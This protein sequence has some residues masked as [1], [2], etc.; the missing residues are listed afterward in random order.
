MAMVMNKMD[1]HLRSYSFLPTGGESVE[2]E[3][4]DQLAG[5]RRIL[6]SPSPHITTT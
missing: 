2:K 1:V 4:C 5:R 6:V 3:G